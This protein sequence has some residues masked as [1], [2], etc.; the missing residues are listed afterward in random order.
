MSYRFF[1]AGSDDPHHHVFVVAAA[2]EFDR[3]RVRL[4]YRLLRRVYGLPASSA[5]AV[6]MTLLLIGT[7]AE[8]TV[9]NW[10]GVAA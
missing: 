2:D 4:M 10:P 6:V 3:R 1:A 5:R 7:R 8:R 9:N